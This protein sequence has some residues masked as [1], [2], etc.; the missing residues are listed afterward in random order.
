MS[1]RVSF[2]PGQPPRTKGPLA[3]YRPSQPVGAVSEYVR[4][5]TAPGDLVVDLFCQG[6]TIL[7]ETAEAG[8]RAVGL[9]VNPLL[10]VAARL[11]LSWPDPQALGAAFTRLGDSPKGDVPLRTHLNG[12]Y[13][14]TCPECRA[15]GTAQWFA[16][17][18]EADVPFEKAVRCPQC[19]ELQVGATTS[20]DIEAA[21]RVPG[22]GLAY[23]YALD[24][25]APTGHPARDRAAELVQRYTSRN[26]SALMDLSRR[27]EALDA[28]GDVKNALTAVLLDC[29]D[30]G[31]K[32]DPYEVD[33]PR[34]RTLRIPT[35]Y[36]ER[37]VW[38]CFEEEVSRLLA[39]EP[40]ARVPR[41]ED[42]AA[43]VGGRAEG[44]A[45]AARAA[46]DAGD[47]VRPGS[48]ALVLADPPRPDG[49]FWAL[50]AL[51]AA[52]LWDSPAASRLRPF[53]RR[54]R[55]DWEWHRRA[56]RGA[57]KA[58]GPLLTSDGHLI[59][60]FTEPDHTLLESVCL[61]ASGAGY[62]LEGWGCAPEVGYR[63]IWRPE[64]AEQ[65]PLEEV[66]ALKQ[67]LIAGA[68]NSVVNTLRDREEPTPGTLLHASVYTGLTE[69]GLLARAAALPEDGPP[70]VAFVADATEQA[71][72]EAPVGQ[73]QAGEPSARPL[74][75]LVEL[76][77]ACDALADRVELAVL[78]L[79]REREEWEKDT[80]IN[81]VYARFSGPLTPD[82]TLVR[83]CIE[84]YSVP[85][86]KGLRLRHEDDAQRRAAE[87][88][89]VRQDLE[90]LGERLRFTIVRRGR[91]DVRWLDE[92]RDTYVVAVSVTAALGL[93][94]L[95]EWA[96]DEGAQRCLVVPG[97]RARLIDFK[98]QRDPRLPR[99]I[100]EG[101]WQFIKFRHL[102]RLM[103]KEDLDRHVLKTVLGLDPIAEREV[104]QIPLF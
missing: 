69:R 17:H 46:G 30:A 22:R 88:K 19:E 81:A 64:S 58:A 59:A 65:R 56:L 104:A 86:D 34:P 71:I 33:R 85:E 5:F 10:L 50:S 62:E 23:Y 2:I 93:Y 25:A 48:V 54:R 1:E 28:D 100:E 6:A 35:R 63:L 42:G 41:A 39:E 67:D 9:S 102:R 61:A 74:R 78:E 76:Q 14:S 99:A 44:Y 70:A 24:R 90:R 80:L 103:A 27:I 31:S 40:P 60:L 91:W 51:W 4:A 37:N 20:E 92:G 26:L 47:I 38:L 79:L 55:F 75:W 7:R 82:L 98:L 101:R 15:T 3:R 29:F 72:R 52:W 66:D 73:L 68:R 16:W 43:L 13:R 11:G 87:V 36:L 53:L 49:V 32:L 21:H 83:T 57:L 77:D 18:H 94:L 89:V 12:L 96:A 95:D 8:R 45:L 84:S 97:G